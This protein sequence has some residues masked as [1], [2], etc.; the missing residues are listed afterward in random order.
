MA[1]PF[2]SALNGLWDA[3]DV[4]TWGQGV[5]VYPQTAADVVN[6]GHQVTVNVALT[7]E[8]G[9]L[10]INSGG[11]LKPSA[12]VNSMLTFGNVDLLINSGGNLGGGVMVPNGLTFNL[13]WNT[14]GDNLKGINCPTGGVIALYGDPAYYGS[15]ERSTLY[16]TCGAGQQYFTVVGDVVGKWAVGQILTVHKN[17]AV[18]GNFNTDLALVTITVVEAAGANTKITYSEAALGVNFLAGGAVEIISRNVLLSKLGASTVI[19]NYNTNRPR[20]YDRNAQGNN[21]CVI[22]NVLVTGFYGIESSYGFQCLKSPVR[23]GN[24]SFNSGTGH[25]VSCPVYSN[26]YGLYSGTGHTVSGP[27]YSNNYGFSYGNGHTVSGPVYSNYCGFNVGNGHTVSGPVYS[28]Y[29]GFNVGNGHTVSGPVYSNSYGLYYGNGHTVSGPV[30]S[31]NYGLYYG[32]YKI[33]GKIGF[34]AADVSAPNTID[35]VLASGCYLVRLVNVKTPVAWPT[36]IT[37]N[38]I[39]QAGRVA[40]EHYGQVANAHYVIDSFG[41]IHKLAVGAAGSP[42]PP[43]ANP[44]SGVTKI[45]DVQNVQSNC[46]NAAPYYLEILNVR[47]WATVGSRIYKFFLQWVSPTSHT[48]TAAEL[49]LTGECLDNTPAGSGHLGVPVTSAE[50]VAVRTGTTDWAKYVSVTLNPA[51][52][53]WIN[54]SLRL[55]YYESGAMALFVDPVVNIT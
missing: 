3:S 47:V 23:N 44:P 36:G 13:I 1:T 5:G 49:I 7:M 8:L 2:T 28:N 43:T 9:A 18:Y 25:T 6:I 27:V 21:N 54:L 10:T 19:G 20:I 50:T 33:T 45:I 29:Y 37:R 12:L 22:S 38:V 39:G 16:A 41:D 51:V 26:N 30:Y 53:G 55:K 48:L 17:S 35:I 34:T 31:N 40:C 4:D 52:E 14:T 32:N 46:P 11:V 24:I 15:V 42:T